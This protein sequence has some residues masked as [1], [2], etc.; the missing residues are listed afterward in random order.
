MSAGLLR[1]DAL[2]IKRTWMA[3][4]A[5]LG[6]LAVTL[7]IVV[8]YLLRIDWMRQAAAEKGGWIVLMNEVGLIQVAAMT[9][10]VGL[11]ASMVF[12]VD[13]RADAWKQL[14]AL[15]LSRIA[16]YLSKVATVAALML[17]ACVL[18]VIG[19]IGLWTWQGYGPLP[20]ADLGRLLGMSW[21]SILP[22]LSIQAVLSAHVKNQAVAITAGV[23]GS[24]FSLFGDQVTG[25]IPW[26]LPAEAIRYVISGT[27]DPGA[28]LAFSAV[29]TIGVVVVGAAVFARRDVK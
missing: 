26:A 25:W 24:I 19:V 29:W 23:A 27:G 7:L 22:V 15:P 1:A 21:V 5:V 17:G 10:G 20:W 11:L 6:P 18:M 14:F 28:I 9:L 3:P 16:A 8:D 12:D 2:K 4:L 13:H